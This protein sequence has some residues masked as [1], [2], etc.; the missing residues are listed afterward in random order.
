MAIQLFTGNVIAIIWDFDQTLIPGYQQSP[1]FS[2]YK[3]DGS[4]FWK[5]VNDISGAYREKGIIFS[6]DTLYLNLMLSYVKHGIFPG[7][8]NALLKEL[9]KE[10]TFYEGVPQILEKSKKF[11]HDNEEYAKHSISVE[12][13]IVSTGLRQTILG[14]KVA[15]MVEDVWGNDFIDNNDEPR[16]DVDTSQISQI[17]YFLDNTTKTRA[18]WEINKGTNKDERIGVND[19][20]APEDRR[21]PIPHMIYIA[22]GPSDIPVFSILNA[23]G[24]RTLG[25]Y[26]PE[27]RKHY[28][29]VKKLHD[30]ARVQHYAPA[31]YADG[32]PASMWI[33][34]TID[35]IA[36]NIVRNRDLVLKERVGPSAKHV[37]D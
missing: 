14:S 36:S 4:T 21:V 2:H 28:L 9:G 19:R 33:Y 29:E 15:A 10:L 34:S 26:N 5:E 20:I 1:L 30:Q 32:S 6:Q 12:H 27:E 25:V 35:E 7:L 23:F 18:I 17:G 3:V 11:V 24:G 31:N 8:N 16:S 37:V 13:Y 22:D